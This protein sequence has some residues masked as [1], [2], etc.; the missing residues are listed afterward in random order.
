[1]EH[2]HYII[3][4]V[5]Q[6]IRLIHNKIKQGMIKQLLIERKFMMPDKNR[7]I[8]YKVYSSIF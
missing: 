6:K 8:N 3:R 7:I 2:R 1:M 4:K 5:F